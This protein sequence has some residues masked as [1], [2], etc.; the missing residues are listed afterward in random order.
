MVH[1]AGPWTATRRGP[2]WYLDSESGH[3]GQLTANRCNALL[4][5]AAPELLAV[6]KVIALT[7]PTWRYLYLNDPMALEQ[8][9]AAITKATIPG[10]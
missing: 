2:G 7:G 3:V 6:C 5:A 1:T 8:L 10:A 4:I 9:R